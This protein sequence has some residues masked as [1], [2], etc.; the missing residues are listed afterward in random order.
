[1]FNPKVVAVVGDKGPGYMWLHNNMPFKEKGGSLYSVQLD[2]KEIPGIE[3]LGVT[4]VRSMADIPEPIDYALVAVPR[5]VSPYVL[6]DLIANG[7]HGAG[8]FTSGFAETGE[9][10]GHQAPGPAH[11]HG[12]G[13]QLQPRRP[14][15]HGAVPPEVGRPLQR[16][17]PRGR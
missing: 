10:L 3:A 16:R 5:Q 11:H 6:K 2:E 14:E 12:S 7:A 8:F 9:E 1:M 4:N 15:L 13:S 17:C